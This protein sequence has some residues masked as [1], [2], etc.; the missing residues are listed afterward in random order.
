MSYEF[1]ASVVRRLVRHSFSKAELSNYII[2]HS[3]NSVK[4]AKSYPESPYMGL[5]M[6]IFISLKLG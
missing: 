2:S 5:G 1:R 3:A 4:Y 6:L